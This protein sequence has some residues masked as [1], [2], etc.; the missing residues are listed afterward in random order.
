MGSQRPRGR[1]N[2]VG[3]RAE[4]GVSEHDDTPED[5]EDDDDPEFCQSIM[6]INQ[7]PYTCSYTT[8]HTNAT[9]S[10]SDYL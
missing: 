5:V 1:E 3:F 6:K 4:E 2:E 9:N 10:H 8:L 7:S